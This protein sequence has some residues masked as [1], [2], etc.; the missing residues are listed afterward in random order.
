VPITM[1]TKHPTPVAFNQEK[2]GYPVGHEKLLILGPP[3]TGKT[4]NV[5]EAFIQPALKLGV[6]PFCILSC[7]FT[8]A[9]ARE[10]RDRLAKG[11]GYPSHQ[12]LETCSTIHAE[13]LR[14]FRQQFAGQKFEIIGE[15]KSGTDEE[16]EGP[17]A[18]FLE[19]ALPQGYEIK[20]AVAL[21]MW[22]LA[23]NRLINDY[24][25]DEFFQLVK[26]FGGQINM[27]AIRGWVRDYENNKKTK[28]LLDFTD[29]LI[30]ALRVAPPER[31]LLI[32]DEAQDCSVLQWK[33]VEKW[34]AK[35]KRVVFVGDFDQTLYEWNGA[36]PDRMFSILQEGFVARRLAKS[37]RVPAKVHTLARSVII[38]N[39]NRIDAPYE[40]LEKEGS[41]DELPFHVAVE[42]LGNATT[43]GH[44]AFVLARSSK[45]LE[46]WADALADAG[47]P[48]INE[49]GKSPWGSPIA[50]SVTRAVLSI[51]HGE[52]VTTQ[53]ARRLIEQFPG[54]NIEYFKKGTT[55]KSCV[56][57]LKAWMKAVITLTDLEALGLVLDK[58]KT[59]DLEE[60]LIELDLA[61]RAKS[62]A[63]LIDKNGR[64]VLSKQ[65]SIRLTTMHGAK[66]R[67]A[68]LVV[69][70][71]EAPM[72][73]RIALGKEDRDKTIEAERRLVYV[74]FTRAK[75]SL[76]LVRNGYD[77][78][79][80][81]G[82]PR[83]E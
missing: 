7:S 12:L 41:A 48:F 77:L 13:A 31:D 59:A 82:L 36:Y 6:A 28:R 58:V 80:I 30:Q 69:V 1:T 79:V 26:S 18:R 37:F 83:S 24:N 15:S 50:L 65:P 34:A 33:L 27:P 29:I 52:P 51:R 3:G 73:T 49:R 22:D 62:I 9:A 25:S 19:E 35:S 16:D 74:A 75:D 60:L 2:D 45:I 68:H 8:R 5:L 57:A 47:V 66:G 23:R 46:A 20:E 4:R 53:D 67:E 14:R 78:G 56:S 70:D 11:T 64:D 43:D 76:I 17:A 38:K 71:M 21:R 72:A 42:E 81:V 10:L 54:R 55:K 39:K 40:P 63:R 61:E 32:V 44:D